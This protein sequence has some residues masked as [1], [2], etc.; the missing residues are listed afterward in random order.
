M[1]PNSHGALMAQSGHPATSPH[2]RL[3][4]ALVFGLT[5]TYLPGQLLPGGQL[6]RQERLLPILPTHLPKASH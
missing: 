6:S 2:P 5:L 1:L 4:W 3:P